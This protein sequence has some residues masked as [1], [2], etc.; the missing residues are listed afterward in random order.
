MKLEYGSKSQEYDASGTASATKVMLVNSE[1]ASVPI[2]LPPD[3]IDLS[4]TE[5]LELAL[6]VIYQENF[7]MRA[8]NEKFHVYSEMIT[9]GNQAR[10]KMEEDSV[11]SQ[12]TL[13]LIIEKLYEKGILSD[14]DLFVKD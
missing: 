4:N 11:K 9:K 1:G 3:K 14:E 8:E 5:L 13:M 6:E 2:F 10:E 7:P 12:G